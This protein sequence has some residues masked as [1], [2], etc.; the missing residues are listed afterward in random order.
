M[1]VHRKSR[2]KSHLSQSRFPRLYHRNIFSRKEYYWQFEV[3]GMFSLF[4]TLY[5]SFCSIQRI[6]SSQKQE[7]AT[8]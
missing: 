8:F 2:N 4:P 6:P 1:I 7:L 3:F 5:W